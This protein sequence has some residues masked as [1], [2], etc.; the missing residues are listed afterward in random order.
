MNRERSQVGKSNQIS[1]LTLTVIFLPILISLQQIIVNCKLN[2]RQPSDNIHNDLKS[3]WAFKEAYSA[4]SYWIEYTG[5]IEYSGLSV[6][7]FVH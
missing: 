6:G 4:Q 7:K 5:E 2:I 3:G 1:R